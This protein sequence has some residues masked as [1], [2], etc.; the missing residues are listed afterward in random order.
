MQPIGVRWTNSRRSDQQIEKLPGFLRLSRRQ[1]MKAANMGP[2]L[3][4]HWRAVPVMNVDTAFQKQVSTFRCRK[5]T[6]I[7]TTSQDTLVG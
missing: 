1:R 4:L 2:N 5:R 7:N 6:Y 3:F